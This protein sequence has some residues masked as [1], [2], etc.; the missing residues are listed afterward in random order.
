[1]VRGGSWPEGLATGPN[2]LNQSMELVSFVL[3]SIV[4]L[5]LVLPDIV[6]DSLDGDPFAV[7]AV[8]PFRRSSARRLAAAT[9]SL[10]DFGVALERSGVS[11]GGGGGGT[12]LGS[13]I[14]FVS[15][16]GAA[17]SAVRTS[18]ASS[19]ACFRASAADCS[20]V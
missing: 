13:S 8:E 12:G 2:R 4:S 3:V 6:V 1:M 16:A 17:V 5:D 11:S 18:L 19:N 20:C 7:D 15:F 14:G 10:R 9:A